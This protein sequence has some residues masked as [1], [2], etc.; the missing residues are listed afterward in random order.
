MQ[1][2]TFPDFSWGISL[3]SIKHIQGT[4]ILF[5]LGQVRPL[6]MELATLCYT[7]YQLARECLWSK[8]S[9]RC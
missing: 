1:T 3:V 7:N 8:P 4:I 5:W 2:L 6:L 9:L